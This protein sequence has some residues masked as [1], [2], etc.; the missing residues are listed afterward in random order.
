MSKNTRKTNS[1]LVLIVFGGTILVSIIAGFII[2]NQ[3]NDAEDLAN[4]K[5]E[6]PSITNQP[7]LGDSSAPVQLVEF[8][9]FK[10]PSC[11]YWDEVIFPVLEEEFISEGKIQ[12]SYINTPFH[13]EES[14]LA[15]LASEAIWNKTPDQYWA[16]H[17]ELF[18]QQPPASNHDDEWITMDKVI[19]VANNVELELDLDG[20]REDIESATFQDEL[21][22]DLRQVE[23]FN[24]SAT[25]TIMINNNVL[26]DPFDLDIIRE[27]IATELENAE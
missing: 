25:P 14:T 5:L 4:D 3:S 10:C 12:Y 15:A 26:E 16:F 8:G 2:F 7:T 19:E 11:K 24:V 17:H 6:S 9:D 22:S 20:L 13:G 23:V 18:A 27:I 21:N 1:N